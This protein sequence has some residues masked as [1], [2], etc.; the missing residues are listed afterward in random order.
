M[1]SYAARLMLSGVGKSGSPAPKSTTS[2]PARRRRSASAETSMVHDTLIGRNS[3]GQILCC[4]HSLTSSFNHK[5]LAQPLFDHRRHQPR[6]I[7]SQ[8]RHF[9]HQLGTDERIFLARHQ[10][11]RFD[12][13][14]PGAGSSAPSGA[15]IRNPK[16]P[17][18]HEKSASRRALPHTR[19]SSLQTNRPRHSNTASKPRPTFRP[20]LPPKTKPAWIHSAESRQ[21][22]GPPACS[23]VQLNPDARW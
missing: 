18:S 6:N 22:A 19:P 16:S 11:S 1:A 13:R 17:G 12:L 9:L 20:A 4:L 15:R 21:S 14:A 8:R 3:L 23:R 2:T 7:A 10:K 5:P